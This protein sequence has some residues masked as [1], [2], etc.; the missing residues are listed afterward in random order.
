MT[1]TRLATIPT[2]P[3]PFFHI[4]R[5]PSPAPQAPFNPLYQHLPTKSPNFVNPAC[6]TSPDLKQ[7]LAPTSSTLRRDLISPGPAPNRLSASVAELRGQWNHVF[8]VK[9]MVCISILGLGVLSLVRPCVR[10][11]RRV[12]EVG[13]EGRGY[14]R[15]DEGRKSS[16]NVIA[17]TWHAVVLN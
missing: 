8:T 5:L 3:A 13:G 16:R 14:A 10:G 15:W 7:H 1:E 2:S 4:T 11:L 12:V 9:L 6:L 17:R